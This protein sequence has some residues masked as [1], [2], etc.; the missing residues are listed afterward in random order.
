MVLTYTSHP[1]TASIIDTSCT[2]WASIPFRSML[3]CFLTD[4]FIYKSPFKWPLPLN[5]N[6]D[7]LSIPFG[8]VIYYDVYFV[9]IPVALHV[10]HGFVIFLP[11]PWHALHGVRITI[12]P[13]LNVW[14]PV[15][16]HVPHFWGWVPGFDFVPLQV[17]HVHF[18][19]NL[20]VYIF[21]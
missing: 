5:L 13:C 20:I 4:T 14:N 6:I 16:W 3:G 8:N 12:M 21:N 9:Y 1:R 7:S 11:Y 17:A 15:P 10:V 2:L 18:L 19:L